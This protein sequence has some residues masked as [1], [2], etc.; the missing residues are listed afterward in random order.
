M[1]HSSPDEPG[2]TRRRRG[3][4]F[5]HHLPTGETVD[6]A[7]RERI[8]ALVIPPAW[9][10]V[11][12]CTDPDAHLQATGVDDAGRTQYLYHP[13]W[14]EQRDREKFDRVLAMAP[15]LPAMRRRLR[16]DLRGAGRSVERVTA[17]ALWLLDTG[18]L[19]V[20]S[21]AYEEDNGSHGVTTL[22]VEHVHD[23]GEGVCLEFPAKGGDLASVVVRDPDAVRALRSLRRAGRRGDHLMRRRGPDGDADVTAAAVADR[24]HDL[25]GEDYSVKDLRTWAATVTAAES[26]ARAARG[27]S[28]D[29]DEDLEQDVREALRA[30]AE[31]LGDTVAVARD[32][33]VDPR[34]LDAH[35]AG[36]RIRPTRGGLLEHG[37]AVRHRVERELVELLTR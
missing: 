31:S 30:A 23:A 5:S 11:W 32:S 22:L 8:R 7:T 10:D 36:R 4:G 27:R 2:I 14:R 28:S 18:R 17:L 6:E 3:R 25:V 19:R 20:G 12:I 34:V 33:Y 15:A 21:A 1:R 9:T 35:R 24:F 13:R 26:L 37:D 16:T 29:A